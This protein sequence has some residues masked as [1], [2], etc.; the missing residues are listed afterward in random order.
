VQGSFVEF[1]TYTCGECGK[2]VETEWCSDGLLP[3]PYELLG[4]V[5]FHKPEC[6]TKY[7]EVFQRACNDV[8]GQKKQREIALAFDIASAKRLLEANG[9]TVALRQGEP[10]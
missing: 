9:F 2:P 1:E 7:L 5:F 10:R 3:G 4:D 6:S 8:E